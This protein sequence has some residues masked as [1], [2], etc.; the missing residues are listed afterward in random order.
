LVTEGTGFDVAA[1]FDP[2]WFSNYR[3]KAKAPKIASGGY[4]NDLMADSTSFD[5]LLRTL[6]S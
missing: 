1:D 5:D 4:L 3:K 6:R 2:L